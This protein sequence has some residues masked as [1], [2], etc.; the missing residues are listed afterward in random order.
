[1][2]D[3][4]NPYGILPPADDP[5]EEEADFSDAWDTLT[6]FAAW[7]TAGIALTFLIR[8]LPALQPFYWILAIGATVALAIALY[9]SRNVR[10]L[11][12]AALLVAATL[13]G[14]WDGL[15][16]QAQQTTNQLQEVLK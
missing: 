10:L 14:H 3:P 13:A 16:Y 5:I 15:S 8:L 7:F 6:R 2:F 1:M 4:Y 9:F 11:A 12:I